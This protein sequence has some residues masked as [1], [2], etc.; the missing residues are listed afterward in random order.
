MAYNLGTGPIISAPMAYHLGTGPIIS[1]LMAYDLEDL[2]TSRTMRCT[3]TT[4]GTSRIPPCSHGGG[5]VVEV[6]VTQRA[7]LDAPSR[8]E[9]MYLRS[10]Q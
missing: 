5:L 2:R 7:Q 10:R 3:Y 4:N 9:S 1:A 6:C 8:L